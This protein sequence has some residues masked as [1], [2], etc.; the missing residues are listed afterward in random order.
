MSANGTFVVDHLDRAN[1]DPPCNRAA[2]HLVK[3]VPGGGLI[4]VLGVLA[5]LGV[6]VAGIRAMSD[7]A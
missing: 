2:E 4:A 1:P 6:A 5:L 7:A 3:D